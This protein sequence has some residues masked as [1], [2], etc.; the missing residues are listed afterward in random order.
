M[1]LAIDVHDLVKRYGKRTVV[2]DV[3]LA[4]EH[5]RIY[6][7]LGPNGSGKTT[8]IR[9]LCGLLTPDGGGGTCLGFDI[10]RERDAIKRQVGYMTQSF[11]LYEDLSIRENLDFVARVYG[12]DRRKRAGRRGARAARALRPRRRSSRARCRA[13]GSSG[14]RWP[15]AS[16]TSPSCCC[17]TSRPP[18]SIPRR[19]ATSGTRST[20]RRRG[21]HRAGLHPLHGRG[22]ALPR[23]RLHRLRRADGARHRRPRSLAQSGLVTCAI[24]DGPGADR[25]LEPRRART[26][27]RRR[28]PRAL[29]R[30]AARQRHATR[31]ALDAAL[32]PSTPGGRATGNAGR[33]DASRTS[34]IHLMGNADGRTIRGAMRRD[35]RACVGFLARVRRRAR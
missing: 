18:A 7:F 13:A 17:S 14:W 28:L 3:S 1:P 11:G 33:A 19:G 12:L 4:V 22:R 27:R 25:L 23:H 30:D 6:G 29:R 9:M 35:G 32:E 31:P 5:G 8:T 21:R 15:P 26:R 10:V 20:P 16:C 2:D 24:G 34:F